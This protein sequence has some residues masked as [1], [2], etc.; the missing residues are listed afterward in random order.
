MISVDRRLAHSKER[1][2]AGGKETA[3]RLAA[4]SDAVFA[5]IVTVMVLELRH[6]ISRDS[7]LSGL[8][9]HGHQ[10]CGELPVHR[11]YLGQS[12]SPYAVRWSADAEIDLDQLRP[13]LLGFAPAFCDRVDCVHQLASS[14]VVFYAVLFVCIDIAYNVFERE[15][16]ARADATQCPIVCGESRS[17]DH[18]LSL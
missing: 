1:S 12:P 7:R 8:M 3:D 18:S 9:A 6:R 14:P 16:F 15:V 2:Y 10:L 13:S 17:A 5:V 11:H 4:F